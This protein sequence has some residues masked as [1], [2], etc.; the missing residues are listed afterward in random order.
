MPLKPNAPSARWNQWFLHISTPFF[1]HAGTKQQTPFLRRT[2]GQCFLLDC[3]L[4]QKMK[5]EFER[6]DP[7]QDAGPILQLWKSSAVQCNCTGRYKS[8]SRILLPSWIEEATISTKTPRLTPQRPVLEILVS[9]Q[10]SNTRSWDWRG[11]WD[12]LLTCNFLN[13]YETTH[14]CIPL[15]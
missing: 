8:S 3:F 6:T 11:K 2:T 12:L 9:M 5:M 13:S 1:Y 7:V 4:K 14:H 10:R 15:A